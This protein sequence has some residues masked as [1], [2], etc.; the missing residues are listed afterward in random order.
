VTPAVVVACLLASAFFSAAEMAFIAANR[1]RLRHLAEQ[2]IRA[3]RGYMEAFQNPERLLSTAM[4]GVTIAHVTASAVTTA[5]LLPYVGRKAPLWATVILTPLMLVFGEILPK[6][7]TQQRA[8]VVA[9]RTFDALRAAAWLLKPLVTLANALVGA[10]LRGLGR[11]ERR[12]PFVSRDDLRLLFQVEPVGVTDVREEERDMIEGIFDLGET[13]VREIMVPLVDVVAVP[14][15][16]TVA[17]TVERIRET[18]HSR[19]PVYR[20]RID[21]IVGVVA[22]LD[23]LQRGS[24]EE[25]IKALTRPAYYVPATKRI[26]D[27]LREMQRQRIRLAVVVDEYGGAEGI[28][29]VEDV[30]EEI[31]G[32]IADERER[33]PSTRQLP[34]RGSGD[35]RR[36]ERGARLEHPEEGL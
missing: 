19:L 1:I 16:A 27:L 11:R 22:A 24:S 25:L 33:T 28:V 26:D 8:T 12:D 36:A 7:L 30:V 6:A 2:G 4:M 23:I 17:E 5:A 21:H 13:T 32:E 18:G 29:T 20:E 34:R 10:I 9:L 14:E 15:E 3:A 31:V 35:D